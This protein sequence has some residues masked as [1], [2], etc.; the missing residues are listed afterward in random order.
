MKHENSI[1]NT[2]LIFMQ[3]ILLSVILVI[4]FFWTHQVNDN[5]RHDTEEARHYFEQLIQKEMKADV[6]KAKEYIKYEISRIEPSVKKKLKDDVYNVCEAAE[7]IYKANKGKKTDAE[8]KQLIAQVLGAINSQKGQSYYFICNLDGYDIL[9]TYRIEFNSIKKNLKTDLI[10]LIKNKSE[11][12]YKSSVKTKPGLK[13]AQKIVFVK[14]FKPFNWLIGTGTSLDIAT[15]NMQMRVLDFI[16]TMKI[17]NDAYF[18]AGDWNGLSLTGPEKGK[19]KLNITD[20]NGKKIVQSLI[21]ISKEGSGFDEYVLPPFKTAEPEKKIS[22]VTGIKEWKWYIGTGRF[23]DD[24]EKEIL[25]YHKVLKTR[26]RIG[27]LKILTILLTACV[28]SSLSMKYLFNKIHKNFDAF[29][30][31]FEKAASKNE[32]INS[33]QMDFLEFKLLSDSANKMI[34]ERLEIEEKR[35][36]AETTLQK[37]EKRFYN[38]ASVSPSGIFQMNKHGYLSY[39]N[40]R[41]KEIMDSTQ[42]ISK[43]MWISVVH[44]DDRGKIVDAWEKSIRERKTFNNEYRIQHDDKTIKWVLCN[45]VPEF[46]GGE[47]K[48]FIGV[49]TEITNQKNVENELRKYKDNLEKLVK[50]RTVELE[51]TNLELIT[52]KDTAEQAVKTKNEFLAN[53]RHEL[54]TPLNAILGM[55]DLILK[56]PLPQPQ[57]E[58]LEIVRRSSEKLLNL[59]NDILDFSQMD[60]GNLIFKTSEFSIKSLITEITDRY[61]AKIP[62]NKVTIHVNLSP[63]LPDIIRS[64]PNRIAQVFENLLANA[65]KFT[66]QGEIQI[67]A[68][69]KHRSKSQGTLFISVKDTGIGI[70]FSKLPEGNPARIFDAFIQCDGSASRQFEGTGLGLAITKKIVESANGKINVTSESGNGSEF[71]V[72]LNVE[73]TSK[74]IMPSDSKISPSASAIKTRHLPVLDINSGNSSEILEVLLKLSDQLRTNDFDADGTF[75]ELILLTGDDFREIATIKKH[76]VNFEYNRGRIIVETLIDKINSLSGR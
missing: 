75:A 45:A 36:V 20:I 46:E 34:D 50:T 23:I 52:A 28:V 18:F 4:G 63:N 58:S 26:I 60:T 31:F 48:G 70:E 35:R 71:T 15:K 19:N 39:C 62:E 44:P 51:D 43:S 9:N 27:I 38:M 29:N 74:I 33:N 67:D 56:M 72:Y 25:E 16:S 8:I 30:I 49:F 54:K 3:V 5:Y 6:L 47:Y 68:S 11:G 53:M 41:F 69:F 61:R 24:I 2:I 59:I 76:I 42:N 57:Q 13:R 37:S 17:Q 32:K 12:F 1:K 40:K 66:E 22:Y 64:D 10:S 73:S 21:R 65:V 14:H 55:S 7:Q